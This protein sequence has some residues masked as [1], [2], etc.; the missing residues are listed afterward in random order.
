MSAVMA[1]IT[2]A[3]EKHS[4]NSIKTAEKK[5]ESRKLF[6]VYAL[7][8]LAGTV[9]CYTFGTAWFIE[10]FTLKG[11]GKTLGYAFSACVLPFIVPDLLKIA[12]A[13]YLGIA[14]RKILR[15]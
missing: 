5:N 8:S 12:L 13:S 9:I 1:T 15:K 2:K 14:A 11:T 3:F 6:I 4:E 7:A 10:F